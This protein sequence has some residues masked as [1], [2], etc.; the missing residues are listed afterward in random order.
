MYFTYTVGP[1]LAGRPKWTD[2][3]PDH[4]KVREDWR[5]RSDGFCRE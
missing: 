5:A 4:A 1:F 2:E 3:N